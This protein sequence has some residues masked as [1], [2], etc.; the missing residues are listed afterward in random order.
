MAS[1]SPTLKCSYCNKN[2]HEVQSCKFK[3]GEFKGKHIWVRKGSNQYPKVENRVPYNKVI[4]EQRQPRF[5]YH[6]QS[7][8]FQRRNTRN[9]TFSN[10]QTSKN[11][12]VPSYDFYSQNTMHYP[13]E[14]NHMYQ[15][16]NS[17]RYN[18]RDT[19]YYDNSRYQSRNN[20]PQNYYVSRNVLPTSNPYL[21][22]EVLTPGPSRQKG[23]YK[24]T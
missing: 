1:K 3:S 9:K 15:Y 17:Q 20:A 22:Y 6:Q 21:Y 4:N 23:T 10:G 18:S 14:R 24:Y 11:H 2:G 12:H 8:P 16:E 19:R 5:S 13:S 7:I